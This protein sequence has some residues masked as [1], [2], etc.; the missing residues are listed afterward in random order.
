MFIGQKVFY[1]C[2]NLLQFDIP[3]DITSMGHNVFQGCSSIKKVL[4]PAELNWTSLEYNEFDGCANMEEVSLPKELTSVTFYDFRNCA[5]LKKFVFPPKVKSLY[6]DAVFY[7]CT[8]LETV[9]LPKALKSWSGSAYCFYD[10]SNLQSL[11]SY[12]SNPDDISWTTFS[13]NFNFGATLYVPK[14]CIDKY[15]AKSGWKDFKNIKEFDAD[16]DSDP[17]GITNVLSDVD[18][19]KTSLYDL[20][21]RRVPSDYKGVVLIKN[22]SKSVRK[23]L[24][25]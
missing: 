15:K 17:T 6:G 8:S 25:K 16:S 10:C 5:K 12:D 24:L 22:G 11:Y 13:G 4:L 19:N 18:A 1:N 3:A 14:G 2:K 20:N 9:V 23:V 7:G 21:G